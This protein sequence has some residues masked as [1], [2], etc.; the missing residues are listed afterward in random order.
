MFRAI[1]ACE[2]GSMS[3]TYTCLSMLI[4]NLNKVNIKEDD[5]VIIAIDGKG[6]WRKSLDSDYKANR[7]EDREKHANIDWD[8]TFKDFNHLTDKL[9]AFTPFHTIV[10]DKMEADDIIAIA[11]KKFQ[12]VDTIVISSDSDYE[13]LAI[14]PKLKI[15]SP[16]SKKFKEVKN[17]HRVLANKI[18]SEKADNL[19]KP[20]L[21]DK[22]YEIRNT[23]VNLMTLPDYVEMPIMQRLEFFPSKAWNIEALTRSE[24]MIKRIKN[25][26]IPPKEVKHRIK[27]KNN[28]TK[29]KGNVKS[30]FD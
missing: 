15:F 19:T 6:N 22:D 21:T 2:H 24:S 8:K 9:E 28:K 12:D 20:I 10:M 27:K 26:Y 13:Q 7:K 16:L 14:Y 5:L 29:E 3:P 18:K 17:P 25:I 4:S 11:S 30:L 23:I 1:Y